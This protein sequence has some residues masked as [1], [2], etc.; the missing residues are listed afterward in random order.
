LLDGATLEQIAF[1][2]SPLEL[3]GG[4]S[5]SADGKLMAFAN[6]SAGAQELFLWEPQSGQSPRFVTRETGGAVIS[7]VAFAPGG[8]QIA[9]AGTWGGPVKLHDLVS[10]QSQSHAT[11]EHGNVTALAFSPEGRLLAAT[12]SDG[13]VL[14]WD[15][16]P[17][18]P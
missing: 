4:L 14:A 1:L 9:H 8:R 10:E 2:P 12:C 6:K 17:A 13:S 3:F 11:G 15:V 7:A 18:S 5:F 16:V